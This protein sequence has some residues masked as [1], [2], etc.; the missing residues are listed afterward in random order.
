MIKS[1]WPARLAIAVVVLSLAGAAVGWWLQFD[2]GEEDM[3]GQ[4]A[5]GVAFL[6]FAVVGAVMIAK[7]PGHRLG[8]LFSGIGV[9]ALLGNA[10]VEYSD[11]AVRTGGSTGQ[12]V[13][14]SIVFTWYGLFTAFGV[15]VPLLY[16]TGQPPS[17]RWWGVGWLGAA[18]ATGLTL[19]QMLQETICVKFDDLTDSCIQAVR[20]PIGFPGVADPERSFAGDVF[21]RLL[22]VSL[23]LAL[24]SVVVR[25]VRSRGV[26]RL[27]LKWFTYAVG[28]LAGQI[29]LIE[30]LPVDILGI[31]VPGTDLLVGLLIAFLPV[32]AGI[33]I[34]RYRL[35]EIDRLISRTFTY[36]LLVAVLAAVYATGVVGLQAVLP[37]EGSD[38]AVAGS[39]L[40]AFTLFQP[41]R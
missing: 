32:S 18:A 40:A 20:N 35:Y 33:A 7:R 9:Y 26:E 23:V 6:A 27:Q 10:L 17:R 15:F 25:F 22:L 37:V 2:K 29:L 16:P 24:A 41:L 31:A 21:L 3:L 13:L 11:W 39:T 4:A 36:A 30:I 34:F 19:L 1:R 12:S 14:G 8:W 28:L 5:L 38:L